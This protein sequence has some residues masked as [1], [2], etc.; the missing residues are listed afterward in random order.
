M[1]YLRYW[2]AMVRYAV[3]GG[4]RVYYGWLAL[5]ACGVVAGVVAYSHQL[6]RGLSVTALSDQVSWGAYIAN[7]TFLVGI[8]AAAVLLVVP[9]YVYK[10]EDVK[11]VV[12]VGELLAVSAI[13]MCL[14]FVTVDIGRPDRILH[15][16]PF[17]GRLQFPRS[18]LAWDVVVLTGYLLLNLHIP[19]Y[20]LYKRYR[21][22]RPSERYYLPFVFLSIIWAIS[23]H[24]VTAFLYSGLGGRPYW[25]TAILAPRFLVSAFASGPALLIIIF[26]TL[27]RFE[28]HDVSESVTELL[29][30]ILTFTIPLNLFLL[31]CEVFK[32]FY[33]DSAHVISARYLFYGIGTHKMLAPY[34]W[35]AIVMQV[36]ALAVCLTPAIRRRDGPLVVASVLCVVGVWVEKG[37]GLIVPGFIPTPAGDLVEYTPSGHEIVICLGIW[38]VGALLFSLMTRVALAIQNGRLEGR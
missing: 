6:E 23:I 38:C 17:I 16:L 5:L 20:L 24:T 7:F 19:G 3:I 4:S 14:L 37:M 35:A 2:G 30:K 12:L 34:I 28:A 29:R 13:V 22:Q 32:E 10:R 15:M 21:R 11:E 8:A 31:G 25:N 18:V 33:T 26:G 27:R 9:S 36:L 1:G